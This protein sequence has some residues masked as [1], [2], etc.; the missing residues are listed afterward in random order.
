VQLEKAHVGMEGLN[1]SVMLCSE[2][3]E[4]YMW[5]CHP[6]LT[7]MILAHYNEAFDLPNVSAG[8]MASQ[9]GTI[10]DDGMYTVTYQGDTLIH[11]KA[12]DVTEGIV[13][14]RPFKAT[15]KNLTPATTTTFD[16]KDTL[17]SLLAH[18]NIASK[19]SIYETYDKQVQGRVVVERGQAEAGVLL[20][21]NHG[22][23]QEI[24]NT[25]VSLSVAANPTYGKMSPYFAGLHA[26]CDASL[27]AASVGLSVQAITDCLCFGNPEKPDQMADFVDGIKGVR[28]ACEAIGLAD[29]LDIPLPIVAGNVSLYNET[30]EAAIPASP[31]IACVALGD[32]AD[33]ITPRLPE[34]NL[35]LYVLRSAA[36]DL[37]GSVALQLH[38]EL[39]DTL[40]D[41]DIAATKALIHAIA[42]LSQNKLIVSCQP[43]DLGGLSVAAAKMVMHS[44]YGIAL[45]IDDNPAEHFS[46]ALGVIVAVRTDKQTDF[47]AQ[48]KT[49]KHIGVSG[50]DHHLKIN[51]HTFTHAE[52]KQAYTQTLRSYGL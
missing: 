12:S 2:T 27:K 22:H 32:K 51:N 34:E 33:V 39:G 17:L 30:A 3:Q 45:N 21:F 18:P 29:N 19:H 28:E 41:I 44:H 46:E 6:D 14:K 20:P 11:A 35:Q 36:L 7:P 48:C 8:A 26:V 23:P 24:Q 42:P 4:R 40:P 47:E 31:M 16:I 37:G 13:V 52:L 9:I 25:A 1:P 15:P 10:T 50:A 49:A 43:I 5:V 38:N